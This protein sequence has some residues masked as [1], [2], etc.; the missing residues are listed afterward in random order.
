MQK[1][2]KVNKTID[3]NIHNHCDNVLS[4]TGINLT[5]YVFAKSIPSNKI[6]D[7]M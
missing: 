6:Q 1:K 7:S 2:V 3:L 5:E 4:A